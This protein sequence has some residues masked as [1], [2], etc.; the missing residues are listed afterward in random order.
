MEIHHIPVVKDFRLNEK[1]YGALQDLSKKQTI[2]KYGKEQVYEWRRNYY[3]PPPKVEPSDPRHPINDSKYKDISPDLLPTG[4]SLND[5]TKRVVPCFEEIMNKFVLNEKK[6][7]ICAH[8][9]V[10]R[11]LV[12]HLD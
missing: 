2:E 7:V 6:V 3:Q 8:H 1:H 9:N 12:K 4:E 10:I 11:A 5:L